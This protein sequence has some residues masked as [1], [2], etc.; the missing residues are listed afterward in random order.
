MACDRRRQG[1]GEVVDDGI[2][3]R[4][5][6]ER[7]EPFDLRGHRIRERRPGEVLAGGPRSGERSDGRLDREEPGSE[8]VTDLRLARLRRRPPDLDRLDVEHGA[9]QPL[10]LGHV[11]VDQL[12]ED[13][14]QD[15]AGSHQAQHAGDDQEGHPTTESATCSSA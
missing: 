13:T 11:R 3:I 1:V 6:G 4:L 15:D 12:A 7:P 9:E 5:V 8:I 10:L 2:G 14:V